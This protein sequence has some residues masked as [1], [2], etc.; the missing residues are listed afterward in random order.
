L[1]DY[2]APAGLTAESGKMARQTLNRWL[3]LGLFVQDEGQ[4]IGLAQPPSA[5]VLTELELLRT[6]RCA[7]RARVLA[8]ENNQEFWAS[9]GAR[10]ADL[11]RSLAWVLAQDVYR[12]TFRDLE[13]LELRQIA[14]RDR[15]LMQNDTRR[16]GLQVWAFFLGFTRHLGGEIDPTVAI[17]EVLPECLKAG[18]ETPIDEFLA[19]LGERLPVLDGGEYRREVEAQI[20]SGSLPDRITGQLSSSLSRALLCLRMEGSIVLEARADRG[21][22]ITMTGQGGLRPDLRFQV[23]RRPIEEKQS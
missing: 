19:N 2:I 21:S 16:N 6:I 15:R 20:A 1:L 13:S 3:E 5:K 8:G 4:K 9:E 23:V 11:T 12:T 18:R 14:N 22:G 7:A 17:R 10:S